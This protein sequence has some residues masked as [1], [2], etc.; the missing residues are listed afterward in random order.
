MPH[1]F[2]QETLISALQ[3]RIHIELGL[4]FGDVEESNVGSRRVSCEMGVDEE[5][6][7]ISEVD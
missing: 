6:S 2:H 5:E 3:E 4:D 1:T 7:G